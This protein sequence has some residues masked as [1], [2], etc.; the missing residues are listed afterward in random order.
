MLALHLCLVCNAVRAQS[1]G[2]YLITTVAGGGTKSGASGDGGPATAAQLLG[3]SGVAFDAAGNLYIGDYAGNR[4][5]K[6][7]PSGTITTVAGTGAN[8]TGSFSNG[9]GGLATKA[10]LAN[11]SGVA[12]D[13]A[14][15][16][17]IADSNVSRVRKVSPSGII[18]TY[19]G[20]GNTGAFGPIYFSGDGGPATT[21]QLTFPVAVAV[22][23]T[24]DLFIADNNNNRIRKVSISGLVI[25]T[26]AGSGAV[27]TGGG[28]TGDGG[29]ATA[30]QLSSPS[31][32]ALDAAGNLYIADRGNNR[33]RRVSPS[34]VIS[35]VAGSGTAA[36]RG[37]GGI[38]GFSGDGGPATTAQLSGPSGVALDASGNFYISDSGNNRIRRVSASGIITTVA[39]SGIAGF[40]GDGGPATAAQL[41]SPSGVALDASG[42]LYI[43][44]NYRIRRL[45]VGPSVSTDGVVNA[46][47]GLG[48]PVAPGEFVTIYGS[49]LGPTTPAVTASLAKGLANVRV[50]FNGTE[51]FVTF[52][53][54]GQ[55]NALVPSGIAG[56]NQAEL[57]VEYQTMPGNRISLPVAGATP[58]IF[59]MNASGTGTAVVVNQDGT[60]NSNVNPAPRG[61]VV[62]FW[63]TGQGQT[64]PLLVDGTQPLAPVFPKPVL[65]VSVTIGGIAVP[66]SD[67]L[68]SGLVYAGVMQVNAR[69]PDR[70]AP[71][72]LVE[73]L[74]TIGSSTSRKGAALP[75]VTLA[76]R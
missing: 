46:A 23:A 38:A 57:Q 17:Y 76:V 51:A 1:V 13:T 75:A 62:A 44:D 21:A 65:P 66:P 27:G 3:P 31:G 55:I 43:A 5:R 15:N 53:S 26:I 33:I 40:G 34:G 69:V 24:G 11:P 16:L 74:L 39:G 47:S 50:L 60:F 8:G 72:S 42:N 70:V 61:S 2:P 10:T 73:L 28:F 71:G 59:T 52:V 58:G 63:A 36:F 49:G 9:D 6:V 25:N 19:A 54:S 12:V 29:P 20:S 22:D 35:T 41:S 37:D 64:S 4:V 48:G 67:I 32:V 18:T 56:A 45:S 7:S 14:G 68:F 30:A